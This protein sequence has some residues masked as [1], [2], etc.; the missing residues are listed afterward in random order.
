MPSTETR[1]TDQDF[2]IKQD[3]MQTLIYEL[4]RNEDPTLEDILHGA[5]DTGTIQTVSDIRISA[6][7]LDPIRPK[8]P[9]SFSE[10]DDPRDETGFLRLRPEYIDLGLWMDDP[11]DGTGDW[12][13]GEPESPERMGI[14]TLA[15][16]LEGDNP[17]AGIIVRPYYGQTL[18]N[19]HGRTQLIQHGGSTEITPATRNVFD[20]DL[21][22]VN[23]RRAYPH[24]N[25]PT[26]FWD[27]ARNETGVNFHLV[28]RGGAG[29]SL[30]EL[31]LGGL[32][33]VYEAGK[34]ADRDKERGM[35]G[36]NGDWKGWDTGAAHK[37]IEGQG[38]RLSD[39]FNRP[40][41]G[42]V[43]EDLWH[44]DGV[45]ATAGE[46]GAVA[47]DAMVYALAEYRQPRDRKM[48]LHP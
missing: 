34:I 27:F 21:V 36:T 14:T 46:K 39:R 24:A 45:I 11:K 18:T 2:L 35:V 1:L 20:D 4:V 42:Y 17:T 13:Y 5:G 15:T 22:R 9:G 19:H 48:P 37:M 8:F 6:A 40:L 44:R 47:H 30:S 28:R 23:E 26:E 31:V 25:L 43:R 10:E 41:K 3:L 38:G 29:D 7:L 33:I 32:D 12:R 16:F